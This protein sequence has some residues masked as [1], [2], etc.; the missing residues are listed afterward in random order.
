MI[1]Y[2]ARVLDSV[3]RRFTERSFARYFSPEIWQENWAGGYRLDE[4][5]EDGRY[6]TLLS[7]MGRYAAGGP[8]LD[9]GCGDGILEEK[10]CAAVSVPVSVLGIDYSLAAIQRANARKIPHCEFLQA[11]Y[12]EF[13][14][15]QR[16]PLIVLNESLYYVDDFPRVMRDLSRWLTQDGVFIVSM[17]DTRVTRRIWKALDRTHPKLQ[18]FAIRDEG[19]GERWIIRVLGGVQA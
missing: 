18:G 5:K 9:V 4:I 15:N 10:F 19:T 17:Y 7:L 8:I 12:R 14:S 16:F 2:T 11:D 13:E 1:P 6:G 3:R